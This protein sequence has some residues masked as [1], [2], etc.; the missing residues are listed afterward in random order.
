M[1]NVVTYNFADAA[2]VGTD[3]VRFTNTRVLIAEGV[4]LL[5]AELSQLVTTAMLDGKEILFDQPY[6]EGY[7]V[8][9]VPL[10]PGD[11]YDLPEGFDPADFDDP[12]PMGAPDAP[13]N[14]FDQF[15]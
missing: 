15:A 11:D 2:D 8:V 5:T 13:F 7:G 12:Y 4:N 9:D 14:P 6:V 1:T 10:D 3:K